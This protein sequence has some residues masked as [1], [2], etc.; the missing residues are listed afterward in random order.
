MQ[1]IT[2]NI[3]RNSANFLSGTCTSGNP[4]TIRV[5]DVS[6]LT[7]DQV[8][9]SSLTSNTAGYLN[10][11]NAE[12]GFSVYFVRSTDDLTGMFLVLLLI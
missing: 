1:P 11:Y 8:I 4:K 10:G 3:L 5:T 12:G 9:S 6:Y 2:G 7:K